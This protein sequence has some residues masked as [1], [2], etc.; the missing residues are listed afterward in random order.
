MHGTVALRDRSCGTASLITVVTELLTGLWPAQIQASYH[1]YT[2]FIVC[3][4]ILFASVH[5]TYALANWLRQ[6]GRG[7]DSRWGNWN[8]S[9]GQSFRPRYGLGVD[10][11]SNRIECQEYFL[12]AKG[13]RCVELTLPLS[14]AWELEPPAT[15][16][17]CAGMALN[18]HIYI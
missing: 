5:V 9:L 1:S 16:R 18:V 17:A 14:C 3:V 4:L 15:V 11:A 6:E 7:F 8:F 10:S 2:L 13:G 12:E